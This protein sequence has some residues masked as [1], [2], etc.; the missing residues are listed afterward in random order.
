M[1]NT[2]KIILLF[3]T[4]ILAGCTDKITVTDFESCAAAGYPIMESYPRQC[5]AN[6][7][8]YIEDISD[9]IFE[10]T[11]EQRN[12]DACIEIYQPVCGKVNVQC[13]TTPCDP[14]NQ[15]YSNSCEACRNELVE[16]YTLGEC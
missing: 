3:A 7:I 13:I 4:I 5:R 9:R 2:I 14:I 12:V 15:T 1:N 8:T 10:C 6:E 11:T 16:S